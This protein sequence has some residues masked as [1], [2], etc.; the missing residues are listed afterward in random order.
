M[1][2]CTLLSFAKESRPYELPNFGQTLH[3]AFI[4]AEV[5]LGAVRHCLQLGVA[6]TVEH[7]R[8]LRVMLADLLEQSRFVV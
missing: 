5:F 6:N 7:I 2:F 1:P 3:P 4:G 8:E